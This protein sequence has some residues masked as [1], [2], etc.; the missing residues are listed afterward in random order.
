LKD[1][2]EHNSSPSV[3]DESLVKLNE[4]NVLVQSDYI[5]QDSINAQKIINGNEKIIT[6]H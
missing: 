4:Q 5:N 2:D 1:V 3:K 6:H